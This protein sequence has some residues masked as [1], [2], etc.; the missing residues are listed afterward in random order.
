MDL[1]SFDEERRKLKVLNELLKRALRKQR[2]N[3]DRLK[4]EI[5]QKKK[6]NDRLRKE[7]EEL[8]K[9]RDRL[10]KENE[11]LRN[12]RDTYQK[13]IFKENKK[14]QSSPEKQQDS[15]FPYDLPAR[16]RGAQKGHKGKARKKPSRIDE[17]KNA[18]LSH[19][20]EC[21]QKLKHSNIY[22]TH[23]VED[24][25]ALELLRTV[26]VE[27]KIER[28]W[29]SH[30][31]KEV[32]AKPYGVI[33][34]S[35]FGINTLLF[36][37]L[38]KYGLRTPLHAIAFSFAAL[39]GLKISQG[40]IV[41]LLHR[42]RIWLGNK[43]NKIAKEIRHS[44]VKHADETGWRI[45][46]MNTWIWAFLNNKN[47]YY[48]IEES[49]G[50]GVPDNFFRGSPENTVLVRDDYAA[51]AKL[52][53][54]HQSCWAHLLRKLHEAAMRPSASYEVKQL[55]NQLKQIY[56]TLIA[57]LKEPFDYAKRSRSFK[58]LHNKLFTIIN[59]S[60]MHDDAQSIQQRIVHQ[61]DNLLTALIYE[62][63]PL[64]N[65]LAERSLRPLVVTRKISG[66][67]QSI[68]GAKTHMVNMSIF[69]SI[70][71]KNQALIPT[72]RQII[73]NSIFGER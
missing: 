18:Y 23:V 17:Y 41:A 52:L 26:V 13:M 29:C 56:D 55:H 22:Y 19:C 11:E 28:Q 44:P 64:T 9:E 3:N 51:Y 1:R 39:Y 47:V 43:Y 63:V 10:K 4:D 15:E 66:G 40:S 67:S 36:I 24:I 33:P 71:M 16:K 61:G 59:A 2:Q 42:S 45:E 68:Y 46:G 32:T 48:A 53:M 34:K 62:N 14:D 7:N 8:E 31:Q 65:N 73:L 6:E 54:K 38:L 49:R 69:Q 21:K 30:C 12:Q 20:P 58:H 37:M 5:A 50:K 27:Y 35:R 25:P 57:I 60:F 70:R 72:L